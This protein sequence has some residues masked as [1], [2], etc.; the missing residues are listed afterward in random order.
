L[1]SPLYSNP[2]K[3]NFEPRVGFAWDPFHNGK[4]AVRGAFG[5]FD[6]QPLLYE[7]F[8][9]QAATA[10]FS[11]VLTQ[12]NLAAGSF[13]FEAANITNVPDSKLIVAYNQSNPARNYVLIWNLNVEQQVTPSVTLTAGYVGNH[14]V[15]MVSRA[16][17]INTTQPVVTDGRLLF[18]FP[19]ASGQRLNPNFG[20]IRGVLWD[21]SSRYDALQASAIKRLSHG[22]QVQGSYTFSKGLDTDS[23]SGVGDQFGNSISSLFLFC[24][25]CR[26][27]LSDFNIAQT[28]TV[29]YVWYV[30]TPRKFGAIGSQVLGGWEVGGIITAQTG[31][32]FTP[33]IGGDPLG[34]NSSD[35]FAYPDRLAAPGC[36]S[37]VNPGNVNAYIN[38]NCFTPPTATSTALA[39]QCTPFPAAPGTCENLFG[40]AGRNSLIGPG[41]VTWDFSLVK[42]TKIRRISETFN[43]QF[44][45]EAF[46]ILNRANF[47]PPI[48]NSTLFDQNGNRIAGAGAIDQTVTPGRQ[49]Q[50]SLKLIW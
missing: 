15:H 19:A 25:T 14:G 21:G 32:P 31:V 34:L 44:R 33:L 20:A 5:M 42:N 40:N 35:P 6:V 7:F 11:V 24:S 28:L 3:A 41:L 23:S 49:I 30:P 46:N 47:A 50:L 26:R 39:A 9:A 48:A 43:A 36:K 17:D 8:F 4:T 27:G 10:P 38:V 12:G 2:T 22:V 29:N 16:D 45:A 37:A 18:P 13:P 1:G